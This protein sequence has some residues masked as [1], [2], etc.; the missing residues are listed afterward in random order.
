MDRE[1]FKKMYGKDLTELKITGVLNYDLYKVLD[2]KQL[3]DFVVRDVT[4]RA[5]RF[6]SAEWSDIVNV[7]CEYVV[8]DRYYNV[9][10]RLMAFMDY[11]HD[12]GVSNVVLSVKG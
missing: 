3:T 12:S 7:R 1:T 8:V 9:V 2:Q 10:E 6:I 11:T 5:R 4:E